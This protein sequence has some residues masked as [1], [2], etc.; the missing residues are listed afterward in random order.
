MAGSRDRAV[1]HLVNRAWPRH[2]ESGSQ[3]PI[4]VQFGTF[5]GVHGATRYEDLPSHVDMFVD[6]W[7][8][9]ADHRRAPGP[10]R[11]RLTREIRGPVEQMLRVVVPGFVGHTRHRVPGEPFADRVPGFFAYLRD[12][13]GLREATIALYG[14]HLRQ[15]EAY[16]RD[17]GVADLC[18]LSSVVVCGFSR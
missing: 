16:L 1:R 11:P 15:F 18:A 6:D 12:E 9:R 7:I 14:H 2:Q 8:H 4:L 17:I 10:P 13:R 3:V 5:A